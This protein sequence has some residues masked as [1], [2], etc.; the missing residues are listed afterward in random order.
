[1]SSGSFKNRPVRDKSACPIC[2]AIAG[3]LALLSIPAAIV[4]G[5]ALG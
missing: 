3:I 5:T 4:L 1:M 2:D